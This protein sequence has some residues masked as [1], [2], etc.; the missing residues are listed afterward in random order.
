MAPVFK[1]M[2][3]GATGN[4]IL[5]PDADLARIGPVLQA[6]GDERQLKTQ[7]MELWPL[8]AGAY[9]IAALKLL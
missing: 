4:C 2:Q 8:L 1:D 9:A 5:F 7:I 6:K 3:L